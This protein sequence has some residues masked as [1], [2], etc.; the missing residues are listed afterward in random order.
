MDLSNYYTSRIADMI[1]EQHRRICE[2]MAEKPV[3]LIV[4]DLPYMGAFPLLLGAKQ[5]RPPIIG[6][7]A[8]P[9]LVTSAD[10]GA[11]SVPDTTPE[12][13][14]RNEV[15]NRQYEAALQP[16][17]NYINA[18]L[19]TYGIESL[20]R[21][22]LDCMYTLP[23]MF[24]EF[25]G[26]AFEFPR[27]DMPNSI[28]FVGPVLPKPTVHFDQPSWWKELDGSRPVVLVTQG[29]IANYNL[30]ELIQP[31]LSA[32]ASENVLV[33]ATTGRSDFESLTIPPNARVEQF[34]AFDRLLP[35]VDVLVTNAG[36]GAVNQA[37]SLGVPIVAAGETEDKARISARVAWSGAGI[38]LGTQNP[39]QAQV[40]EA[41]RT[42]LSDGR[43]REKARGI[44]E[45]FRQY[46]ALTTIAEIVNLVVEERMLAAA[47][48]TETP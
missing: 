11:F 43:Y 47:T 34:V 41:I 25:T 39:S 7:G 26:E 29:T 46:N 28:R 13:L 35:K 17:T 45:N 23:D 14:A 40:A 5:D 6:F 44:R 3:D 4:T 8:I 38:S 33:I 30:N 15:E 20:S 42:V 32:L 24:L 31:T 10:F 22:P 12:G 16:S 37:L 19:A 27:S 1:P 9:L 36:Y 2:I 21:L 18:I 48:S